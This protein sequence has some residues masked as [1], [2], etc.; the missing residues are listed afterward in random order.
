LSCAETTCKKNSAGKAMSLDNFLM[1]IAA[2]F[3]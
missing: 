1:S 2:A 3:G